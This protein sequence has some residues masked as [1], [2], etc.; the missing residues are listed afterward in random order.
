L[1]LSIGGWLDCGGVALSRLKDEEVQHSST[2]TDEKEKKNVWYQ[3]MS[4]MN[5]MSSLATKERVPS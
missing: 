5:N 1:V 3:Y 2:V 4:Y